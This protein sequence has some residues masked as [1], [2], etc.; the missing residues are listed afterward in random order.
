MLLQGLPVEID[1]GSSR[2]AWSGSLTLSRKHQITVYD[3]AYLELAVRRSLPL[4][5]LDAALRKAAKG[6]GVKLLP[7]KI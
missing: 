6:E 1:D 5:S 7:E 4:G 2:E 3:A